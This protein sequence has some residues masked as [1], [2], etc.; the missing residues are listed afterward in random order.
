[1]FSRTALFE[2]LASLDNI[3]GAGVMC[4]FA[5]SQSKRE[6]SNFGSKDISTQFLIIIIKLTI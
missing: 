3:L 5:E 1:M 2:I 6:I 4:L